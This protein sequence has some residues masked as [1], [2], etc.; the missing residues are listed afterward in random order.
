MIPDNLNYDFPLPIE[1]CTE[2]EFSDYSCWVMYEN[3]EERHKEIDWFLRET[4]VLERLKEQARNS[5]VLI[6]F[7]TDIETNKTWLRFEL[8][9]EY[10]KN[11]F[12]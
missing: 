11:E 8:N 1:N 7:V 2:G 10:N 3:I 4:T 9:K 12:I 6:Y 5:P